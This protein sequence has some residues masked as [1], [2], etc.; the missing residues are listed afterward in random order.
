MADQAAGEDQSL[1]PTIAP[2][3]I[4]S[5]ST[6]NAA[7]MNLTPYV[8]AIFSFGSK[9]TGRVI[10]LSLMNRC[11]LFSFSPSMAS[12]KIVNWSLF[13]VENFSNTGSSSL[14]VGHQVAQNF[15]KTGFPLKSLRVMVFP[16][17]HF[18]EKWGASFFSWNL[19]IPKER[20]EGQSGWTEEA[21]VSP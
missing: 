1:S 17:K 2:M 13:P 6:R 8:R 18:K 19:W 5:R 16:S 15:N 21:E 12:R 7:G 14:Q 10:L 20:Q 4:P 9:R 3:I 11:T